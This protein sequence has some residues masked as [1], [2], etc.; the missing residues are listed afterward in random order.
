MWCIMYSV[1]MKR[2][3]IYLTEALDREISAIAKKEK[4][5]QAEIVRKLLEKGIDRKKKMSSGEFLLHLASYSVPG[6]R[7]LSTNL[8]RY[9][10]GDKSPKY[11]HLYRKKKSP[12]RR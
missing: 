12:N 7:D 3:Q 10:Y 8:D 4:K 6:P 11:G 5:S 9:L 1:Y 2:K